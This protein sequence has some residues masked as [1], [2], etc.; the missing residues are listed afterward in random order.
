VVAQVA[1]RVCGV[2]LLRDIQKLSRRGPGQLAVGCP[3]CAGPSE[4]SSNLSFK[5]FCEEQLWEQGFYF[6]MGTCVA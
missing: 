4:V 3:A 6:Q 1:W 5:P 2:S